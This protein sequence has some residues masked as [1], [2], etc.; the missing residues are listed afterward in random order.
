M[1]VFGDSREDVVPVA[2][3]DTLAKD[4]GSWL[5]HDALRERFILLSGLA[6]GVADEEFDRCGSDRIRDAEATLLRSLTELSSLLLQSWNR[7]GEGGIAPP[8]P[9]RDDWPE[10]VSIKEPEGYSFYALYPEAHGLAART[11]RLSGPARIIGIRSIGSGL[12]A[13]AAAALGDEPPVTLRPGGDP[14]ARI[15]RIDDALAGHLLAGAPHYVIV[16][17]GPGLSGSSFGAVAD[18]LE[19]HG[20]PSAR[21]SFLPGHDQ[22]LGPRASHRHRRRWAEAQRPVARVDRLRAW[23]EQM[24]G[25]VTAWEDLSA[26]RWR[27][28]LYADVCDWPPVIPAWER[29]KFLIT[30]GG[31]QWMVR[32]AGLGTA[33]REKLMLARSL[34]EAGFGP[35][36]AGLSNGWLIQRWHDDAG[37][38]RP[39]VG[40]LARYLAFRASLAAKPGAGLAELVTMAR[41]NVA[42]LRA[43]DPPVEALQERVRPVMI[44][45]KLQPHEW[46]RRTD[47][48]VLKADAL[49]HHRGHD[50]VGCQDIAWDV[51]A[52]IE[53]LKLPQ[54]EAAELAHQVGADPA[55]AAISRV[56]YL[57]FRV[58]VHG[59]GAELTAGD[60]A[61]RHR[62]AQQACELALVDAIEH[63]GD[64]DQALCRG[65]EPAA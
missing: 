52:A 56:A 47:G 29:S 11:L 34:A 37:I 4:D 28:R 2:L 3:L 49:D 51:A 62:A 20:V 54:E 59:L 39:T 36:V 9:R 21:I 1:L 17:E 63:L 40:E 13:M 41:R 44:D 50:L 55:L 64:V 46:L 58:G 26:G 10:R 33:G 31:M 15:L 57:A 25:P 65:I 16:D 23:V 30:A 6:Q 22:D 61:A 48:R 19:D 53:E 8:L 32:F 18:W 43:W 45:G 5:S 35:D 24:V 14:F 12:A 60:E 42:R 27:G 38:A 7:G